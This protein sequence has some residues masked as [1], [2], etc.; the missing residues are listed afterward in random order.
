MNRGVP[1]KTI[2]ALS[3]P[4]IQADPTSLS[5]GVVDYGMIRA[6]TDGQ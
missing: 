3:V 6:F 4:G 2:A 1:S 5:P